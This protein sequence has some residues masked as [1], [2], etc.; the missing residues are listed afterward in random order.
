MHSLVKATTSVTK[1]WKF[2]ES[3]GN[4]IWENYLLV[5][6]IPAQK[7]PKHSKRAQFLGIK[8]LANTPLLFID[9]LLFLYTHLAHCLHYKRNFFK[10]KKKKR[11]KKREV[12]RAKTRQTQR[13]GQPLQSLF[14]FY[15]LCPSL[16]RPEVCIQSK[17][18]RPTKPTFLIIPIPWTVLL[19][20]RFSV[21]EWNLFI[22]L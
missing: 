19:T 9:I 15:T 2:R 10:V 17:W 13:Q 7:L 4:P 14:H 5:K 12:E 18:W 6:S 20:R 3:N 21:N 11:K 16:K 22:H 1:N 8:F